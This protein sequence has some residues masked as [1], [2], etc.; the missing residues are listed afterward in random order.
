MD[1]EMPAL[2]AVVHIQISP[3]SRF[4]SRMVKLKMP[5]SVSCAE[6]LIK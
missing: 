6:I 5:P 1:L 3:H 2:D 4:D